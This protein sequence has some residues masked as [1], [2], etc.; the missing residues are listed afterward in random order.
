MA[1]ALDKQQALLEYL[2][3]M[4]DIDIDTDEEEVQPNE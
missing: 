1:A 2:A 3:I 4:S